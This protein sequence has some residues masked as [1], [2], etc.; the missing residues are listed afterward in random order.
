MENRSPRRH[1]AVCEYSRRVAPSEAITY[2]GPGGDQNTPAQHHREH[3]RA[4]RAQSHGIPIFPVR[5][6]TP[7][8]ITP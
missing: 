6:A 2:A 3:V 5:C 4:L 7:Y 8:A 1:R